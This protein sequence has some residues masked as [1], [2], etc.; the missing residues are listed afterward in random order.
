VVVERCLSGEV[1]RTPGKLVPDNARELSAKSRLRVDP[2]QECAE[3]DSDAWHGLLLKRTFPDHV[4]EEGAVVDQYT[5]QA[6][7][8]RMLTLSF[9]DELPIAREAVVDAQLR[10]DPGVAGV[11]VAKA[12]RAEL[13]L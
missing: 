4:F 7:E 12:Y 3:F 8:L 10:C 6:S 13:D 11:I 2:G 9:D 5:R 1:H